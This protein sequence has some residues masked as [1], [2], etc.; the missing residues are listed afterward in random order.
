MSNTSEQ[1][2]LIICLFSFVTCF[3][4][5]RRA[6]WA[7]F[8]ATMTLGYFYGIIRA[9]LDTTYAHF[10]YDFGAVGFFLALLIG[11][12]NPVQRYKLRRIMPWLVALTAWPLLLLF[13]PTQ[14]FLVQLVGLRGQV[15]FLPFLAAGAM[16]NN[17]DVRKIAMGLAVLNCIALVFALLEVQ[18]GVPA[19]F[20]FNAVD[21]IIYRST[22]VMIGGVGTFR[23]PAIFANAAAYGGNM[24]SSLPLLAG[25]LVQ[26]RRLAAPQAALCRNCRFGDWGL[27]MRVTQYGRSFVRSLSRDPGFRPYP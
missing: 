18:F 8:I 15:F 25:V 6:L 7:G 9:N 16:A 1:A 20:P 22:D 11:S 5:G 2:A 26:E 17:E 24:A 13:V 4:L 3:Y 23:I 10:L 27:S 14:N 21:Q 12:K 19:F